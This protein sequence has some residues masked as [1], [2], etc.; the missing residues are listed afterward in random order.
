MSTQLACNVT[1]AYDDGVSDP[2]SLQVP[3]TGTSFGVAVA[4]K[5]VF[6]GQKLILTSDTVIPYGGVNGLGYWML[7]NLDPT[8]YIDVKTGAAGT[9]IARLDPNGGFLAGKIGSGITA[10]NAI[11]N[12]ASC[13]M[14]ILILSL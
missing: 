12:T 8:N 2:V 14:D 3:I 11:A 1:M 13:L 4:T 6:R 7:V 5:I 10:P 9:I